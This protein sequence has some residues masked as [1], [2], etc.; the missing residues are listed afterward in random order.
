MSEGKVGRETEGWMGAVT[1][2]IR[3]LLLVHCGQKAESEASG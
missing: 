2:L 3:T 1:A